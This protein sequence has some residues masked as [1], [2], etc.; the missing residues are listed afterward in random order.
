MRKSSLTILL[1]ILTASA[2]L[3]S[4]CSEYDTFV[5]P[6]YNSA[7]RIPSNPSPTDG[8]FNTPMNVTLSWTCTDPDEGDVIRYDVFVDFGN[9]Y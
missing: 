6:S 3:L 1:I 5:C 7:P 8:A 4:S 2:A 9:V